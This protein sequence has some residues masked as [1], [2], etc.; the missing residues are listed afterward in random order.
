MLANYSVAGIMQ[1]TT[2]TG[3]QIGVPLATVRIYEDAGGTPQL[4]GTTET[5]LAG[6]YEF[7]LILPP[8]T[9]SGGPDVFVCMF[10]DS[11]AALVTPSTAG[12]DTYSVCSNWFDDL[13]ENTRTDISITAGTSTDAETAF[14]VHH[15]LVV[16]GQYAGNLAGTTPS[17]IAVRYDSSVPGSYYTPTTNEIY[18]RGTAKWE[19]DAIHHEYG[20]Y[21]QSVHQFVSGPGGPHGFYD[22]LSQTRGSKAIGLPQAW[23]EGWPT[24]FAVS[25]Q[26]RSGAAALSILDVGDD[27]YQSYRQLLAPAIHL[28]TDIGVGEDNEL[29]VVNTVWDLY[30]AVQDGVDE[31]II[32]DR[33]LFTIF[34]NAKVTTVG[35]AWE[36]LAAHFP[37]LEERSKI[38]AVFGQ[39]NIAP[40]L[41]EPPNEELITETLPTFKWQKN[42][43][44]T[45]NPLNDFR[46]RIYSPDFKEIL[47][48]E[49]L[50]DTD[51]F[52]PTEAQWN[53]IRSEYGHL[54]WIIEG[55]NT[56]A[57]ASPGG[58][59]G[60]YWSEA[61]ALGTIPIVLVI[62]DTGSMDEEINSVRDALRQYID[63]VEANLPSGEE[64]PTIQLMTFK[65][66]VTTRA[67]S[68]DLAAIRS[69]VDALT[70]SD[71]DDCPE[72]SAQALSKAADTVSPGGTILLATDAATRPGV[73]MSTVLAKL[74]A[75]GVTV[76]TILSGDCAPPEQP[77]RTA[78][79]RSMPS[80]SAVRTTTDVSGEATAKA[81]T[82]APSRFGGILHEPT[83]GGGSEPDHDHPPNGPIDD[84]GQPP[85]DD[86][87]NTPATATKLLIDADYVL[88]AVGL[89]ADR[90][91][92][93]RFR[94]EA[95]EK[96]TVQFM[97]DGPDFGVAELLDPDT[98]NVLKSAFLIGGQIVFVAEQT[99][100]YLLRIQ[101]YASYA[102]YAVR[103]TTEPLAAITSSV[104]LMSIVAAQT[105]GVFA[106]RDEVKS[107]NSTPYTSVI[108]NV[109]ASTLEP[110]V[111]SSAPRSVPAGV[112]MHLK[113]TGRGTNWRSGETTV[114]F[115]GA[116]I[117][118]AGITVQSVEVL[119]AT[120]L[121]V[122]IRV[123]P[124]MAPGFLDVT[125]STPL[126]TSVE[127]AVGKQVLEVTS[128]V[129][130]P[131][132]LSADPVDLTQGT[133][134]TIVLRGTNVDWN[135][136]VSVSLGS[137]ITV[138]NVRVL[139]PTIL[140][141]SAETAATANI[142]FRTVEVTQGSTS[143]SLE[144]ALFVNPAGLKI[145]QI[146]FL[147]QE[148]ANAG[149]EL[150]VRIRTENIELIAGQ[151]SVSFGDGIEV[152]SVTVNS[153]SEALARIRLATPAAVG[154]RSV[155]IT[156]QGVEA[157]LLRGFYV[158][159]AG[160]GDDDFEIVLTAPLATG[161][162]R[163]E[164]HHATPGQLVTLVRG[165]RMGASILHGVPLGIADGRVVAQGVVQPDGR[166]HLLM[167]IASA[168]ELNS[169]L[170]QAYEQDPA[171]QVSPVFSAGGIGTASRLDVNRDGRI[172]AIDALM[173]INSLNRTVASRPI[174]SGEE[175]VA[176][177]MS[178]ERWE[179]RLDVSGDGRYTALDALLVIN[180]LN[181]RASR[182]GEGEGTGA[183]EEF[184]R[185]IDRVTGPLPPLRPLA[186]LDDEL[187]QTLAGD[188]AAVW[189]GLDRVQRRR[190]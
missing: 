17:Q 18:I 39:N 157:V 26:Q 172:S 126:G 76:N 189:E 65:D 16:I 151:T 32:S 136:S 64:P 4:L 104:E 24:F 56:T 48:E 125:A 61:R 182:I 149:E 71:G 161:S 55:R 82:A 79:S 46:I 94:L 36:A 147:D 113:L 81:M 170:M 86:H 168:A 103:V 150:S 183:G 68:N 29:S 134:A 72:F 116:G 43:G 10:A 93:F 101:T 143:T 38:A 59:L 132:I 6:Q 145:P 50:G 111:L 11:P 42:G 87:G 92:Y 181:R 95:N 52:T 184:R 146:V 114:A 91:D 21:F 159:Q 75:K 131:T 89:G 66:D 119:S 80:P 67:T 20:H 110:T 44:G 130:T 63:Y 169:L 47:F 164:I 129:T 154:F 160:I 83:F 53:S 128:A 175:A 45:P 155:S 58:A 133:T 9:G 153:S 30:D 98:G 115:G 2:D 179:S 40:V 54:K 105:G 69:A 190:R 122:V 148:S 49:N 51:S 144:R 102:Q 41:L 180:Y 177:R 152:L 139:S 127:S 96:Y 124:G 188:T 62:D 112:E 156:S 166:A 85:L 185:P 15:A 88:G 187:L 137:G 100:D 5:D 1:W 120:T 35:G 8:Q 28:D 90:E 140:E 171:L 27:Q 178:L 7:N 109:L 70:A 106:Y 107:G 108:Y 99:K 186:P 22:N 84:P 174:A 73:S 123:A 141:I 34:K 176:G 25:G 138:K 74:R 19:W 135:S 163:L 57:P 78:A 60:Y 31:T 165:T 142:G 121:S 14:S 118:G 33:Q 13:P 23:Q 173:V 37:D 158:D 162:N 12:A 117:G 167:S 97:A 3:R 77:M